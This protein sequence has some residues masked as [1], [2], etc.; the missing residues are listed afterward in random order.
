MKCHIQLL[1]ILLSYGL[2][3]SHSQGL[4]PG[5]FDNL[6]QNFNVKQIHNYLS[7]SNFLMKKKDTYRIKT[8]TDEVANQ[9]REGLDEN[10][11][12]SEDEVACQGAPG[13][14]CIKRSALCD[15][16]NDCPG[17]LQWDEQYN[18]CTRRC[19]DLGLIECP[20]TGHCFNRTGLC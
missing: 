9:D 2:Q 6:M 1:F 4:F 13:S 7:V 12:C 10:L 11:N 8:I 14:K 3:T 18:V 17:L 20:R 5:L 19:L 15:G 16:H